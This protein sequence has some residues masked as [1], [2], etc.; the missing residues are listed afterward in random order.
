ML[1]EFIKRHAKK[2]DIKEYIIQ[3]KLKY[4]AL[5]IQE[6]C[7]LEQNNLKWSSEEEKYVLPFDKTE[8]S[9]YYIVESA[10]LGKEGK[11]INKS[12]NDEHKEILNLITI[13][14]EYNKDLI[15]PLLKEIES[16]V[17]VYSF[18]EL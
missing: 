7:M 14:E 3:L 12:T 10:Y 4:A 6:R 1:V 17:T 11:C 9:E 15:L 5:L 13:R 18:N 16:L 2:F 8:L